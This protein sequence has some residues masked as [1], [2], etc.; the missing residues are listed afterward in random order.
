MEH[1]FEVH[2]NLGVLFVA[3]LAC[4]RIVSPSKVCSKCSTVYSSSPVFVM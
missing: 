3:A 1:A 2:L 4:P